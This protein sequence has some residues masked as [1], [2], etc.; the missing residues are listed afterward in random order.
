MS[1]AVDRSDFTVESALLFNEGSD[2]RLRGEPFDETKPLKYRAGWQSVHSAWGV[3]AK[4]PVMPLP[5]V[6]W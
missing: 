6:R 4:W 3:D 5:E 1:V 2:A